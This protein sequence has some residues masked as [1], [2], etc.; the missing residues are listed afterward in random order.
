MAGARVTELR[1]LLAPT[2]TPLS[3]R[4]L[5]TILGVDYSTLSLWERGLVTPKPG[6]KRKVLAALG[7]M[8]AESWV[9]PPDAPKDGAA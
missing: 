2:A 8:Y 6:K 9:F 7:G 5:E 4:Q 3:L 1:Q